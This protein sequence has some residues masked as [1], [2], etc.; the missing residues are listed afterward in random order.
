MSKPRILP[1]RKPKLIFY[2]VYR[3]KSSLSSPSSPD[4][5]VVGA[6]SDVRDAVAAIVTA[7]RRGGGSYWI[8]S[9]TVK[10]RH[11]LHPTRYKNEDLN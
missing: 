4:F 11:W 9:T 7:H 10:P 3:K 6:Y 2:T 5:K 8:E 1:K